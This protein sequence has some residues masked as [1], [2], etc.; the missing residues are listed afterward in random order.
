MKQRIMLRSEGTQE[1]TRNQVTDLYQSGKG[2]HAD[3]H[4]LHISGEPSQE[5]VALLKWLQEHDYD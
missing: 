5:G 4:Y 3:R 2:T 1:Q